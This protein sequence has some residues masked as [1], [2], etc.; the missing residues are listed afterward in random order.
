MS[1]AESRSVSNV[2]RSAN[3]G[4]GAVVVSRSGSGAADPQEHHLVGGFEPGRL[5]QNELRA[6]AGRRW[7]PSLDSSGSPTRHGPRPP[8][9]GLVG[10]DPATEDVDPYRCAPRTR[11]PGSARASGTCEGRSSP[12][13]DG[14][15][16]GPGRSQVTEAAVLAAP[17]GVEGPAGSGIDQQ[18]DV[19]AQLVGH[20]RGEPESDASRAGRRPGVEH[21]PGG[22]GGGR[23]RGERDRCG[24]FDSGGPGRREP[25]QVPVAGGMRG[26]PIDG[27]SSTNRPAGMY[28][29]AASAESIGPYSWT[30]SI[31]VPSAPLGWIKAT[32]VPLDPGRGT[33]SMTRPPWSFTDSRALAQSSTR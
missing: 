6:T 8:P 15:G 26:T 31:N 1:R 33:W 2:A 23:D 5:G 3:R 9:S 16:H 25:G 18:I 27:G 11:L 4:G 19:R 10:L 32:V 13:P 21:H 20:P 30:S 17:P 29:A 7:L 12:R 24:T 28:S 22:P 14:P